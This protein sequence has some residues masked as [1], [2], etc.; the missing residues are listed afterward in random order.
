[1]GR[2]LP[3]IARVAGIAL[4]ALVALELLYLLAGNLALSTGLVR[5]AISGNP[6][7]MLVTHGRAYTLLPGRVH[8]SDFSMR[9]Q[10]QNIQFH[11]TVTHVRVDIDLLALFRK[12]FRGDHVRCEGVSFRF[13]HRVRDAVG[14]EAR[15]AAYPPIPGFARPALFPVPPPPQA[16][17]EEIDALWTVRLD[18]VRVD[19]RELWFLEQRWEGTGHATGR[20]ELSPMRRLRVGPAEL[21]LDGGELRAGPHVVSKDLRL[22]LGATVE[23]FDVQSLEGMQVFRPISAT[24]QLEAKDFSPAL[25][26]LYVQGLKAGGAGSLVADVR[27]ESGRFG[28][29]TRV[30]LEMESARAEVAGF[31]YAG[32]PRLTVSFDVAGKDEPGVPRIHATVPGAVAVPVSH[33]GHARVDLTGLRADGTLSGNDIVESITL[34]KLDARLEE[35]RVVDARSIGSAVMGSLPSFFIQP[36]L[37]D[38]PLVGSAAVDMRKDVT[39]ARLRYASLGLAEIRGAARTSKGGWDGAAAGHIAFLP[40]GVRLKNSKTE[41]ALFVS[42]AWLDAEL[43]AAGIRFEGPP[44]AH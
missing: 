19:L 21:V 7:A 9:M 23:S 32:A 15:L 37:G 41:V 2:N 17:Q 39:I 20:F 44:P 3:R 29:G 22:R 24:V 43:A 1:M 4:V 11:L 36:F 14:I 33:G 26:A 31:V 35:A 8:V 12:T 40:I 6:D 28:S 30:E 42:D 18:D 27:I 5:R 10:D 34:D 38:G 16:T 25:L 13:V